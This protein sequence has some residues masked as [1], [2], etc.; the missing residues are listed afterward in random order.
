M[1]TPKEITPEQVIA[2]VDA[3]LDFQFAVIVAMRKKNIS[4]EEL[5]ITSG[6]RLPTVKNMF[7]S[8]AIVNLDTVGKILRAVGLKQTFAVLDD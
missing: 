4:H 2:G 3:L 7:S 1:N 5:S 6:V 8:D